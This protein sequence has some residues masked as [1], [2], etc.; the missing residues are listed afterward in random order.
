MHLFNINIIIII[1]GPYSWK[2]NKIILIHP[3]SRNKSD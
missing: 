2:R 1:I 3:Y